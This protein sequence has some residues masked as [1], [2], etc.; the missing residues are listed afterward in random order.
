MSSLRML[1]TSEERSVCCA[2]DTSDH[3]HN[4]GGRLK[5]REIYPVLLVQRVA[6][7][8]R[9]TPKT[10]K[11]TLNCSLNVWPSSTAHSPENE[12][13]DTV[14]A[15][16]GL[17]SRSKN[18]STTFTCW[19]MTFRKGKCLRPLECKILYT[20]GFCLTR[21]GPPINDFLASHG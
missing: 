21:L 12:F 15:T 7:Q 20:K 18:I 6:K 13:G 14:R 16:I 17:H 11:S 5:N 10:R 1:W 9:K 8:R 3:G 4:N 2:T 19:L